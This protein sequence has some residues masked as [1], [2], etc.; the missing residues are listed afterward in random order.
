MVLMTKTVLY[1]QPFLYPSFYTNFFSE[2]RKVITGLGKGIYT[3]SRGT[4]TFVRLAL[5]EFM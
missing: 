4:T 2:I 5:R 1:L 3:G